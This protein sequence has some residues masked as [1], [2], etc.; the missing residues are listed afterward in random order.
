[1]EFCQNHPQNGSLFHFHHPELPEHQKVEEHHFQLPCQ[2]LTKI[3]EYTSTKLVSTNTTT[4]SESFYK[5]LVK[6]GATNLT[7]FAV[8]S[9]KITLSTFQ[10]SLASH[11]FLR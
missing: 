1:M 7:F 8:S 4:Q 3:P 11:L 5:R 9:L 10:S 6:I 2:V